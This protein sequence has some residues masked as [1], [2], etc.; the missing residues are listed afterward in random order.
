MHE[1][2]QAFAQALE[3]E[4]EAALHA[5]FD[6]LVRV[7]QDK[8]EL[9]PLVQAQETPEVARELGDRAR[10]NLVLMRMLLA[11]LRGQLGLDAEPT[12]TARGQAR[13]SVQSALR[14]RL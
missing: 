10:K 7:Q 1:A 13:D 11:C 5:D 9:M 2:A 8:L 3:V 12:Y 14:G 4:R 6:T